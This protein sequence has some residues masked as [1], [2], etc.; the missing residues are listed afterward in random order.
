MSIGELSSD[1][2]A[3]FPVSSD[4]AG[5]VA[6]P[7]ARAHP[8]VSGDLPSMF[9]TAPM[10][11]RA[12][13]GYD[14]FQVDTYVEWAED[15]LATADREREHLVARHL[16]TRVA[17]D[18]ARRLLAHSA[19][20]GEFLQVS[21][22]IGSM[23]AVAADEA[24]S[25]RREAAAET[26]RMIDDAE[27][28]LT[29]AEAEAERLVRDAAVEVEAMSAEAGR[30]VAEAQRADSAAR[31]EAEARLEKVR[32]MEQF[33]IEQAAR[34]RQQAAADAAAAQVRA[35]DEV[36]KML[37]TGRDE[38]RRTD[39]AAAGARELLERD[40]AARCAVLRAEVAALEQRR[41][42]FLA[43]VEM[44]AEPV[45][46]ATGRPWDSHLRELLA[47]LR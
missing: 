18:E 40:L 36:V 3:E 10:F 30:I 32:L 15:E 11:R 33:A 38:R 35:R 8:N 43:E 4:P 13:G 19:G 5:P 26:H 39:A 37:S 12:V 27:R 31:A 47:R 28:A 6:E 21:R 2:G 9:R 34:I 14:R 46:R 44:A 41:V 17:L 45:T 16:S 42:D 7:R 1:D 22:R 29:D 25:M 23:L 24:E 20:G